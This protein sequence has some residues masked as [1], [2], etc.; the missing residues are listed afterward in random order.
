M[1]AKDKLIHVNLFQR[2]VSLFKRLAQ[3]CPEVQRIRAKHSL[4]RPL[5]SRVTHECFTVGIN[6]TL[7]HF[8]IVRGETPWFFSHVL[9]CPV[10]LYS[11]VELNG[12]SD[13]APCWSNLRLRF[14]NS[15]IL[16]KN[17]VCLKPQWYQS[18]NGEIFFCTSVLFVGIWENI[19]C[20]TA[21]HSVPDCVPLQFWQELYS[22]LLM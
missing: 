8:S 5:S 21:T 15:R 20:F 13:R 11:L 1:F 16:L 17:I 18:E 12:S 19:I 6:W 2:N 9:T 4:Y 14:K 3:K 10:A 7:Q 22:L